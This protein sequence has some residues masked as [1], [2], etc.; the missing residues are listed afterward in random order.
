MKKKDILAHL[1]ALNKNPEKV[2]NS[3]FI[4]RDF[5]DPLDNV[6][7]KYEMLRANQVD[8]QKVSRI[9]KQFNYSREAFYVILRKFKKHGIIG[10]LESSRQRKNTVML[11]QDIVKM[12]IQTKF[13][14]PNISGSKLARKINAKFNTDYK[15]RAIEKAVKALGLTKKK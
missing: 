14:N 11:N 10:F 2:T 12:I 5:F 15:K 7:I 8:N 9:C 3:L 1:G 4:E 6:Q 13:N